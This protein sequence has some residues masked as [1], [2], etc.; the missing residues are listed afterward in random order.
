MKIC[1]NVFIGIAACWIISLITASD[2]HATTYNSTTGLVTR[3]GTG[4]PGTEG[5]Y[6]TLD[7]PTSP[8]CSLGMLFMSPSAVQY[9]ETASTSIFAQSK[10]KAVTVWYTPNCDSYGLL[11]IVA[12]S[13]GP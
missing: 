9:W 3:I 6:L 2:A 11:D 10:G 4:L 5:L 13:V 7:Q 1:F 12:I 8:V